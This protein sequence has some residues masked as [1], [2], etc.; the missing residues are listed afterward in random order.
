MSIRVIAG[1]AKGRQLKL[2]PGDTTRPIMDRVKESLFNIIGRDILD[3]RFLDLFAGTGSVAIEALSR[4][5]S[6]ALLLDLESAAIRTIN[7]NLKLT[8]FADRAV[9]RK[10]DAFALLRQKPDRAY[11]FIYIAPPQYQ[12][13]WLAALRALDANLAWLGAD[14]A[15][16]AQIDPTEY[17]AVTLDHLLL[18]DERRYGNT[19]LLF[20]RPVTEQREDKSRG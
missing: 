18:S 10:M 19:L 4:G 1:T 3:T 6:S 9:V 14:G 20:Y 7:D 12:G 5:A 13:L 11:D 16:I 2:V 8:G 15:A 17:Q